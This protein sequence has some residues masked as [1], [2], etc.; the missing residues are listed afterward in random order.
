M[1]QCH[2]TPDTSLLGLINPG[3]PTR[4]RYLLWEGVKNFVDIFSLF[5]FLIMTAPKV[6]IFLYSSHYILWLI[7]VGYITGKISSLFFDIPWWF[8]AVDSL[9][10]VITL[11]SK[12]LEVCFS[13]L[14]RQD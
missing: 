10:T 1:D 2:N 3:S 4:Y 13:C 8:E 12:T 7:G 11:P 6:W 14:V 9:T 5:C